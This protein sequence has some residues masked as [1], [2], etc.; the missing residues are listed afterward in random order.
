MADNIFMSKSE[1]YE[2]IFVSWN[3]WCIDTTFFLV[4]N[5]LK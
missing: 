3:P 2:E 4:Y 1:R 5:D